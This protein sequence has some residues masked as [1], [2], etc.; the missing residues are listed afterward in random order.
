MRSFDSTQ[1]RAALA[2]MTAELVD[3]G[4]RLAEQVSERSR[5][6]TANPQA[7][8]LG[9]QVRALDARCANLREAIDRLA[10]LTW[11]GLLQLQ[12]DCSGP[13]AEMSAICEEP[14]MDRVGRAS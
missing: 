2:E 3:N 9:S 12:P 7:R 8:D 11:L 4:E 6:S 14:E 13:V 10:E 1:T 5:R